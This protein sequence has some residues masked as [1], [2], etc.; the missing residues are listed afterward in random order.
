MQPPCCHEI[1]VRRLCC[2]SNLSEQCCSPAVLPKHSNHAP[3][4]NRCIRC[5]QC[6]HHCAVDAHKVSNRAGRLQKASLEPRTCMN[7]MTTKLLSSDCQSRKRNEATPSELQNAG[8][9]PN[10]NLEL[11]DA[12]AAISTD[13]SSPS[14]TDYDGRIPCTS[15]ATST[16]FN[17]EPSQSSSVFERLQ[18][19]HRSVDK[20]RTRILRIENLLDNK[21]RQQSTQSMSTAQAATEDHQQPSLHGTSASDRTSQSSS[22]D[23]LRISPHPHCRKALVSSASISPTSTK[24]K[25]KS[26]ARLQTHRSSVCIEDVSDMGSDNEYEDH[27][28]FSTR[29]SSIGENN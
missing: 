25:I 12:S 28:H 4:I 16:V 18:V 20:C 5:R 21:T 8:G 14:K 17:R 9:A 24:Q 11:P 2:N 15:T 27:T 6:N 29:S 13:N 26:E 10:N 23:Q 3:P 19:L 7:C 1:K 22:G